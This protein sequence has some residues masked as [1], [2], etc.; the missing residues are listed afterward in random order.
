[1]RPGR[2]GVP[3][4]RNGRDR[5]SALRAG[6]RRRSMPRERKRR[7]SAGSLRPSPGPIRTCSSRRDDRQAAQALEASTRPG[8][9]DGRNHDRP[10]RI[11]QSVRPSFPAI[12]ISTD[13]EAPVARAEGRGKPPHHPQVDRRSA[14]RRRKAEYGREHCATRHS[15]ERRWD[16][17]EHSHIAWRTVT[18]WGGGVHSL[19]YMASAVCIQTVGCGRGTPQGCSSR[20]YPSCRS[21]S[22]SRRRCSR[23]RD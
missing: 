5:A 16:A 2:D 15:N 3:H 7:A 18:Q 4:R 9:P 11:L 10:G 23:S 22:S 20:S 17:V 14:G 6:R 8:E 19:A 1:M 13:A 21:M 12:R